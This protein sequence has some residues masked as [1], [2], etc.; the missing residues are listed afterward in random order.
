MRATYEVAPDGE[1][2]I[3]RLEGHYTPLAVFDRRNDAVKD[4]RDRAE[5]DLPSRLLLRDRHGHV[6]TDRLLGRDQQE[7][8]IAGMRALEA[9]RGALSPM[10]EMEDE[11]A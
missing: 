10:P 1:R 6:Q 3:V 7:E 11:E 2:W 9:H 4:A 8:D 5:R